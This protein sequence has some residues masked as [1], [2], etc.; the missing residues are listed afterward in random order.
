MARGRVLG[1]ASAPVSVRGRG[2]ALEREAAQPTA[3]E[4]LE[5]AGEEVGRRPQGAEEQGE[6][7]EGRLGVVTEVGW[8]A[9][10]LAAEAS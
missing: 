7:A 5:G 1:W 2:W 8:P 3:A 6:E 10:H 9:L 4:R